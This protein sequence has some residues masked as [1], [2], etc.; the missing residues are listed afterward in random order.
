MSV[1]LMAR[2]RPAREMQ[3][4]SEVDRGSLRGYHGGMFAFLRGVVAQKKLNRVA[5]DV[6]G[7]GFDVLVPAEV[8][9]RLS[10][11][12]EATLLTYC[13]IREDTFQIFGFLR[14]EERALFEML[15]GINGVG[16]KV[17]LGV[18]SAMSVQQFGQAVHDSNVAAFTRVSGVG[19][20][21]AQRILLEMKAKLGE[22]AELSLILGETETDAYP[23]ED[24]VIEALT[25]LGCTIGEARKAAAQA[26]MKLGADA[27]PE[28]LVRAALQSMAK[29]KPK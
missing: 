4:R 27:P 22:D 21:T 2:L 20:K 25:S 17:A 24:D 7:V 1:L 16:P 6:G 11:N 8:H 13:H 29:L 9:R 5:L 18:L 14:E 3:R 15:L 10:V 28:E 19:K 12:A 23:Q 26:R